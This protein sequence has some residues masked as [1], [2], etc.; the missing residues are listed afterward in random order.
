ML[1]TKKK[2]DYLI[3]NKIIPEATNKTNEMIN[4]ITG[5][6]TKAALFSVFFVLLFALYLGRS[7]L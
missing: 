4:K 2:K 6:L 3:I 7:G 5:K 1:L